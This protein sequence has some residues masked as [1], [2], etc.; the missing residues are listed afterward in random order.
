MGG[1]WTF[2][3]ALQSGRAHGEAGVVVWQSRFANLNVTSLL[4]NPKSDGRPFHGAQRRAGARG[5]LAPMLPL[6]ILGFL[7]GGIALAVSKKEDAEDRDPRTLLP[8]GEL[9]DPLTDDELDD[10]DDI[11]DGGEVV[12]TDDDPFFEPPI[13]E[14][15]PLAPGEIPYGPRL[16]FELW[17]TEDGIMV[18][19]AGG[20]YDDVVDID[21]CVGDT[22]V[23]HLP[24]DADYEGQQIYG[25]RAAVEEGGAANLAVAVNDLEAGLMVWRVEEWELE[26]G[27]A[28]TGK[29][30]VGVEWWDAEN[31]T[32]TAWGFDAYVGVDACLP[33]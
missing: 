3:L 30:F 9:D 26:P 24:S 18:D 15:D 33:V 29:W 13:V 32:T 17:L 23:L 28:E 19:E 2:T 1:Y 7:V 8:T 14:P 16:L 31:E 4:V 25:V 27:E 5:R 12:A 6:V 20:E 11:G 22:I 21:V 10:I